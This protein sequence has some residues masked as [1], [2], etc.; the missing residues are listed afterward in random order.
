MDIE[1][2]LAKQ[3]QGGKGVPQRELTPVG[4]KVGDQV[5]DIVSQRIGVVDGY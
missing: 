2:L 3:R 1:K 5:D 4:V